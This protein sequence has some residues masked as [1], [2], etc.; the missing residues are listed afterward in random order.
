MRRWLALLVA[1]V[2]MLGMIPQIAV[3]AQAVESMYESINNLRYDD[4]V[5]VSGKTVEIV[6]PGTPTSYQVGYGVA[7]GT[8]D[9]AVVTLKGTKLIA[10]G[11]GTAVVRIDGKLE[12]ITVTAAPIS[13]LLLIGQSNMQGQEGEK[14]QSIIC[15]DGMVYG[16]YGNRTYMTVENATDYAPSALTG[17]GSAINVNG[18]T[19]R[20]SERPI[21]MYTAAGSGRYGPD[22]AIAY[23]WVKQTGEKVFV[24]NA[25]HGGSKISTWQENGD[26]YKEAL[27]LAGACLETL[28][29]E[30]DAGHYTLSH[31]GYF[32]C[33][34]CSDY[35]MTAET[36]VARYLAMHNNLKNNLTL[37]GNTF[38]FGGIIT[39]R[40]GRE[41]YKSYRQGVYTDT[42]DVNY[43]ES[44][45]D[46]RFTGPRV[47]QYWMAN[48]PE[49]EDIWMVCNI[50]EEWVYMPDGT[51]GVAA[52]FQANYPGGR[53]DYPTQSTVSEAWRTPTTPG[54]VHDTI[55]YNQIGYN[56][57]GRVSARNALIMLGEIEAPEVETSV[58]FLTWDGYH[59]AETITAATVGSSATLVVPKVYPVWKSKE[60]TYDLSD[61]LVWNYYDLLAADLGT[62]GTLSAGE[63][64]SVTV[65]KVTPYFHIADHLTQLPDVLCGGT[66]LW[67]AL[68]H[69]AT[70]YTGNGKYETYTTGDVASIT[71][72]VTP[73]ERIYASSF[74][75]KS[76]TGGDTNGIRVTFFSEY[77][78][79]K[80][81]SA[82]DVYKLASEND[83]CL[84]VPEGATAVC[85][86]MWLACENQEVYLPD[87]EH[88]Y[89]NG[90][91]HCG[92]FHDG[93][94]ITTQP[95]NGEG[96][97]GDTVTV[98][99]EAT[100][101]GLTYQ[102]YYKE[103]NSKVFRK[104]ST[105]TAEYTVEMNTDRA[106][107]QLYCV[108]TDEKGVSV[109]TDTVTLVCIQ[110]T[111]LEI[112]NQPE[113]AS[114][115]E[116][117]KVTVSV[118]AQGEGLKYQW[119]FKDPG[120][121]SFHKT[122]VTSKNYTVEM[123]EDRVNRQ[124][125]CVI[126]DI[127]GNQ[128]V[129]DTVTLSRKTNALT[130]V[131]QPADVYV[132]MGDTVVIPVEAT[133]DG[134]K[135]QWYLK[136]AD[137]SKF[138]KS[139]IKTNTYTVEMNAE[140]AE[141]QVYCVITDMYGNKV[142]T[143]VV[144]M[145]VVPRELT[146]V[147]QP[148]DVYVHL[149]EDLAVTVE[150]TGDGLKYQWYLKDADQ[151]KF[152]KSSITADTYTVE[153]NAERAERTI[154][155]VITD[156]Y[157]NKVTTDAVVL[158]AVP[159]ELTIVSQPTSV[160]VSMGETATIFVDAEGDGLKY[161]WYFKDPGHTQFH[162]SAIKSSTYSVEMTE[163]RMNRK[164]RCVIT[165]MYG[166]KVTTEI[167]VLYC[168]AE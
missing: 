69:D 97:L 3:P 105:T 49:L 68:E 78:V 45:K 133:G 130:I 18:T 1:S 87:R 114:A 53:V 81:V 135:Y 107:R 33:Q 137:Q 82:A 37:D 165:D 50:G 80:S 166:N 74:G 12:T 96:A 48:N 129:S 34:G 144:T 77:G 153:M 111:P 30:I 64:G 26:N 47:A 101:D 27:L 93:P 94:I 14:K 117:E 39:T 99:V 156:M 54:A 161:Q 159:R 162:K 70:Y 2:L 142:T 88:T 118:K 4:Y 125:Y 136:D 95:V 51:D 139:S 7:E 126:T 120:H 143:E 57:V 92:G 168:I 16:I 119:Y 103:R 146:I 138:S 76:V 23:E 164:L 13:F 44:F 141:R 72:P 67:D 28:E 124:V 10:T 40:A 122:S 155:C 25:A 15:P 21:N 60:V 42:T 109:T 65:E 83:G 167:A 66:N 63:L 132:Q 31:M 62:E 17:A 108:I 52:Y 38:E 128:V 149:G 8:L 163:D 158:H 154:Y 112:I 35:T 84:I 5:N 98:S 79:V 36:Y 123:N 140:R 150:A 121:T 46:L 104:S 9:T 116:G 145:H 89:D 147:T 131:T 73:G 151:S 86:P 56:E 102:W 29:K 41:T 91:C 127:H 115:W 134:L 71:I 157:G 100:G 152:H 90:V 106:Y 59:T 75:P 160:T 22:S 24:V 32:W 20:I 19:D 43:F 55:H 148:T 11:I 110:T 6:D 85:I 61:G 58:E 113:D